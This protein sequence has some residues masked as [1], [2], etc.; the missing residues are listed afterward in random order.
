MCFRTAI[1]SKRTKTQIKGGVIM[2]D[3]GVYV[4]NLLFVE[5]HALKVSCSSGDG[6]DCD[7]DVDECID[8]KSD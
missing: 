6:C 4:S 7:G 2:K 1:N 5:R 8:N 3:N